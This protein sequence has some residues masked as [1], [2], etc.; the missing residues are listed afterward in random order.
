MI[1]KKLLYVAV[2]CSV[3]H[4]SFPFVKERKRPLRTSLRIAWAMRDPPEQSNVK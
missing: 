1:D 2:L 3:W 4:G